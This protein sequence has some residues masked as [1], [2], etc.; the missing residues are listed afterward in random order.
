MSAAF[1]EM[2]RVPGRKYTPLI[3]A[4]CARHGIEVPPPFGRHPANRYAVVRLDTKPPRLSARTFFKKE[5]LHYYLRS[6]TTELGVTDATML[7]VRVLDFKDAVELDVEA[8]GRTRPGP[9]LE[10]SGT[11]E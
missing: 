1:V 6:K 11:T 3:L 7:S 9:P 10:P 5:D 2:S 4:Y 8:D